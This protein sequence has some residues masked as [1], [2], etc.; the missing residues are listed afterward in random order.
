[1][2]VDFKQKETI[3]TKIKFSEI[4]WLNHSLIKTKS[5]V[6]MFNLNQEK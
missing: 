5:N 1:M 2:V 3:K 4:N 6:K